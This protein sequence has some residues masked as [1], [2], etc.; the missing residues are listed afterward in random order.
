MNTRKLITSPIW[1]GMFVLLGMLSQELYAEQ[2]KMKILVS[3][4]PIALIVRDL[5]GEQAD[6]QT[7]VTGAASPHHYSLAP[8]QLQ[9]FNT[10]DLIIW[11]DPN[12]EFFMAKMMTQLSP[13][14]T[15]VMQLSTLDDITW[16]QK[17]NDD[18][19][20][21]NQI[22]KNQT[23]KNQGHDHEG[24]YDY[25][26]WLNPANA[27]VIAKNIQQALSTE[28]LERVQKIKSDADAYS[29]SLDTLTLELTKIFAGVEHKKYAAFHNAYGHFI[30]AFNLAQI[31][32]IAQVPDEQISGKRLLNLKSS[33]KDA[34]CLIADTLEVGEAYKMSRL[35]K[36][37]IVQVDVLAVEQNSPSFGYH[38]YL[39]NMAVNFSKC[40]HM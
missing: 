12:F 3:I 11:I 15:T 37:P 27:K 35:L 8:S 30:E 6:V 28:P 10:A 20:S 4:E 40:L 19:D 24:G 5:V 39:R 38:D 1:L 26:L 18:E 2:K 16:T 23:H 32:F 31:D 29:A 14:K 34:T 17:H 36:L 22:H 21:E 9:Q 25:H 33:F 7:L 13:D